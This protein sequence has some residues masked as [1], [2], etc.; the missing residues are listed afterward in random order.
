MTVPIGIHDIALAT[1]H[2]AM[3]LAELARHNGVDVNKY[4]IG[5]GQT[6]QT[7]PATDEDIVTMAAAAAKQIVAKHGV[8]GI[9]TILFATETGIDQSKAAAVYVQDLIGLPAATRAVEL[10][11]ACY[12]GTSALQLAAGIVA[13]DPEQR[14]LVIASDIA[15]YDVDSG[16]EGTQGAAAV[17]ML[18][19]AHPDLAILDETVGLYTANVQDFWR[20]NYR[21]TPLVDGK[22]SVGA[23]L[24]AVEQAWKDYEA[25]G[26]RGVTEFAGFCYHQPF[27]KMAYK[28]HTRL[29]ELKGIEASTARLYADLAPTT[30]Y[31]RAIG[32]SYTASL[33]VGLVSLLDHS[34]DLDGKSVALFSYGSGCVAELFSVTMVPG[35]RKHLRTAENRAAIAR[36]EPIS[37]EKYR[38]LRNVALP[39][40]GTELVLDETSSN[41]FRLTAIAGHSR[42]YGAARAQ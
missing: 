28:A 18:V 15:K 21:S 9:R 26:G 40:D 34:E 39:E 1:G 41:P 5:L 27:T 22:L 13:R 3:D 7:V 14:V 17:A 29:L 38:A 4:Y 2:Y 19:S 20:P 42:I 37:Y 25:R 30:I 33:F 16:G 11:Q 10:K 32:N 36:R 31:N 24:E 23:Y 12:G 6:S 8:E 35:Y